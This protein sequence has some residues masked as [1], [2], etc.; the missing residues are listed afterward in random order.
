MIRDLGIVQPGTTLYIP[1]HTFD[2]NDPSAS[3]TLTGL[4]TTDIEIYKDGSTTQR[5]S[6]AGYA[7]LDTDGI[8]FDGITGIHGLSI[9]LA[10]N[11]TAGFYASGSQ[12]WVVI[13]SVTVDAATIN[14]VLCT[15]RIGYPGAR[16]NTTIATLAS[17]TSFTLTNGPAEDDALNGFYCIIHDVASA[18]QQGHAI[19][20]DYTGSTKTVTLAAGTTFT[21]AA[22]DNIAIMGPAPLQPTVAARTLDVSSGGEAGIDWANV[23]TPGSTVSLSSTTVA[24]VSTA[25]A[26]TTVNGLAANTITATSIANDA[27]TAAKIA[28]GAVDADALAVDAV[29]E[30]ADGV[31]DE[32]TSGH[33]TAGTT[34]KALTDAGSAGDPWST[35]LPG[36]YGAGTAGNIVGNNLNATV[37]S[38]LPTANI[39]LSGGAVTVGTNNDKT[40]YSLA[41]GAITAAVVATGAIDADALATDAVTE[42]TDATK[43]AFGIVT[44]TADS[45]TTTTMVDAA[46]TQADTDY[47]K[48][49]LIVFTSGTISG[50]ARLITAFTPGSDT[51]T[52]SP[53]TTQAV[54]TNT[55]IIVPKGR[56]D[57]ELWQGTAAGTPATTAAVV[58]AVWDEALSGHTTAG[59]AG[60]ALSDAGS[61]GDPWSTALPGAYGA[62]TAGKIIGDNINATISSRASQTSVD[63]VD[64]FLDTEIAAI[65]A[66]TDNLPAAPAATGDIPSAATIAD[67][68][69]DEA[70]SGHTTAGSAGKAL[71]D[72]GAAGDPWSTA[73]SGAYGAGTAGNIIGNNLNATVGSRA[74]QTSVDTVDDFLD[75]EIA[76]IK[77]KTDSLTFTVAGQVDAN[78][79]Y[80]ND[81]AVTGNG[82]AGT[83]WGP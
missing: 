44:G 15:F 51:V 9:N 23:G 81:T 2:S 69:W 18:V 71:G 67:A 65:K 39:T 14:F 75:T 28:T 13:S 5:A 62:G 77:A 73:L 26:V 7:L 29:A 56:S 64:D 8:D 48:G 60:K 11:S 3:V 45:G 70:L 68:V 41:N 42:I 31:W 6:D 78:I 52:F 27:I 82:S 4:A 36:A 76:A 30:I 1:F 37:S 34:G 66:K 21:A 50:Q 59:S 80:V 49:S 33:T 58:D 17:Q 32:A 24:T 19:I 46:L 61:A 20:S 38:R 79:Q 57:I 54:G 72:A 12:Y 22:S 55:Y 53:A 25:T 83:P 16:L 10:D 47:W 35:A 63:T 43:T 74:T 40:G